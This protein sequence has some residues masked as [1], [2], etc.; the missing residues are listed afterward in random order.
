MPSVE[1]A[2]LLGIQN[3]IQAV[4]CTCLTSIWGWFYMSIFKVI[5][6]LD[7]LSLKVTFFSNFW[8]SIPSLCNLNNSRKDRFLL[9]KFCCPMRQ[10]FM[11]WLLQ[12][13][14]ARQ[15]FASIFAGQLIFA[16]VFPKVDIDTGFQK[17]LGKHTKKMLFDGKR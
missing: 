7:C 2:C 5:L 8:P 16:K 10:Q 13:S 17:L 11:E 4:W 3:Q 12:K 6:S 14:T 15:R 1:L 9:N